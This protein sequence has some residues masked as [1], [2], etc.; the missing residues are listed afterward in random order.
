MIIILVYELQVIV[1]TNNSEWRFGRLRTFQ[2]VSGILAFVSGNQVDFDLLSFGLVK[3]HYNPKKI[4]MNCDRRLVGSG[5]KR[6]KM[7]R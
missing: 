6:L 4:Q 7:R 5:G 3:I 1:R 2:L